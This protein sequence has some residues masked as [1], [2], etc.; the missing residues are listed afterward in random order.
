MKNV[1]V[2][3]IH[4]IMIILSW[5]R[6]CNRI[7]Q[8]YS[9]PAVQKHNV[10][11]TKVAMFEFNDALQTLLPLGYLVNWI[12]LSRGYRG[13]L[14]PSGIIFEVGLIA[15]PLNVTK[16][17]IVIVVTFFHVTVYVF[18]QTFEFKKSYLITSEIN[19]EEMFLLQW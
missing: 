15:L 10:L 17:N 8:K 1:Y 4:I 12:G 5:L 2:L 7:I 16:L 3:H 18:T 19:M 13:L 6:L 14:G 9:K 11:L